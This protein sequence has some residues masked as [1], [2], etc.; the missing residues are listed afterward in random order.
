[1]GINKFIGVGNLGK[2]PVITSTQNAKIANFSVGISENYKD[3]QGQKQ[4]STEWINCVT[5]GKLSEIVEKYLKK[6]SKVYFEGKIKT[7]SYEKNG[8][9]TYSTKI[10]VNSIEMLSAKNQQ[11]EQSNDMPY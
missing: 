7:D 4:T 3:K 9:T 6:G 8:Q 5:F 1:M 10:I 11:S 2:D